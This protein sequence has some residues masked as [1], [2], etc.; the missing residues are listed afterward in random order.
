MMVVYAARYFRTRS[1]LSCVQ[2]LS[3]NRCND[4]TKGILPGSG[5]RDELEFE[6]AKLIVTVCRCHDWVR[7]GR[8]NIVVCAAVERPASL[9]LQHPAPLLEEERHPGR[10]ALV[11]D[12]ADPL[13]AH[14]P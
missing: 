3:P 14:G 1:S 12:A 6:P 13:L 10:V 2:L 4:G 7:A 8:G 5:C 9:A 11:A